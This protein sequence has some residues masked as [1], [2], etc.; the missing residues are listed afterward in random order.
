MCLSS[1]VR[2]KAIVIG[3]ET[4]REGLFAI[5]ARVEKRLATISIFLG[6]KER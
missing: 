5:D 3:K 1:H 4:G 2:G 6:P